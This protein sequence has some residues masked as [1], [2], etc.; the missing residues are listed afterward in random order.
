MTLINITWHTNFHATLN[1]IYQ[2]II[3]SNTLQE[4]NASGFA[5]LM[6]MMLHNCL[7]SW[8]MLTHDPTLA[9]RTSEALSFQSSPDAFNL[10]FL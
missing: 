10:I 2:C 8:V 3:F 6:L 7:S 4:A 1:Q 5:G 9:S